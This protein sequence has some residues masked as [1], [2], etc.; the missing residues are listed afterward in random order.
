[1]NWRSEPK[2]FATLRR[3]EIEGLC[4]AC[5]TSQLIGPPSRSLQSALKWIRHQILQPE[6]LSGLQGAATQ[7]RTVTVGSDRVSALPGVRH[8]LK[9]RNS[10]KAHRHL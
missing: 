2:R 6:K 1:M 9:I 5:A 10:P 4:A 8:A 3:S 7:V